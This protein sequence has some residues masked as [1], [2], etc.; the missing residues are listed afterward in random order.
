MERFAK[1]RFSL[2]EKP[3]PLSGLL[4][5]LLRS[6]TPSCLMEYYLRIYFLFFRTEEAGGK[7]T[8]KLGKGTLEH[9][10]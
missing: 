5:L 6:Y 7:R 8:W 9:I 2:V 3:L 1:I 4:A 10:S